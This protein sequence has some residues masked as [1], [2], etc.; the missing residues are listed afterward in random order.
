M[1]IGTGLAPELFRVVTGACSMNYVFSGTGLAPCINLP[2]YT[3]RVERARRVDSFDV[4]RHPMDFEHQ[5]LPP[6]T[7]CLSPRAQRIRLRSKQRLYIVLQLRL[8]SQCLN[9]YDPSVTRQL[10]LRIHRRSLS[11]CSAC[12]CLLETPRD[13]LARV[14]LS[15]KDL[16]T[17]PKGI[18]TARG[19]ARFSSSSISFSF[20]SSPTNSPNLFSLKVYLL[21]SICA[22]LSL[23]SLSPPSPARL[24][25]FLVLPSRL[26]LYVHQ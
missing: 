23:P 22:S 9:M 15:T 3:D 24:P 5:A 13:P 17:N 18:N 1:I 20:S 19:S 4:G 7:Q 21:Q 8:S 10:F 11:L 14:P 25:S 12:L 6:L 16:E 26:G 2:P